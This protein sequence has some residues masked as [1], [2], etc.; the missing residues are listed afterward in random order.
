[1][2][3][4]LATTAAA[5]FVALWAVVAA[6]ADEPAYDAMTPAAFAASDAGRREVDASAVDQRLMAAAIRHATNAARAEHDLRPLAPH[7]A[8]D[9][10]SRTHA[11]DMVA[12]NFFAHENPRDAARRT[13]MD[14]TRQAGLEPRFAAENIATAFALRYEAGRTFYPYE[15]D[16]RVVFSYE[17]RGEPIGPHT[18]ASFAADVV[19]RWMASPG[20]RANILAKEPTLQGAGVAV[21]PPAGERE[22]AEVYCAQVFAAPLRGR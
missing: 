4:R 13:H 18:Y 16:G 2:D 17:P 21:K 19:R 3:R 10:A 6:R 14:R 22:M 7:A 15:R 5:G 12:G 1:V 8:L 11:A 20:H 9:E